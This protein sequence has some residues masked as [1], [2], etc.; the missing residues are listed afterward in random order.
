MRRRVGTE[1]LVDARE[2]LRPLR[3]DPVRAGRDPHL[4]ER[5]RAHAVVHPVV[6][7]QGVP[8]H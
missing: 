6:D 8:A 1:R 3:Q 2:D 5:A 7:E 4:D